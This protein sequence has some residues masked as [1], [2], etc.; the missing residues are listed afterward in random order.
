M[1]ISDFSVK[2]IEKELESKLKEYENTLMQF[3]PIQKNEINRRIRQLENRFSSLTKFFKFQ[4][5]SAADDFLFKYEKLPPFGKEYWF[6]YFV[7][8]KTKHQLIVTFGR[9]SSHININKL[10]LTG[11]SEETNISECAAVAWMFDKKRKILL[12][13]KQKVEVVYGEKDSKK[14]IEFEGKGNKFNFSGKYP[15][16]NLSLNTKMGNTHLELY[17]SKKGKPFEIQHLFAGNL[18]F[19]LVNLYFDFKGTLLG[20]KIEGKCYV[21]KVIV[22]SPFIPWNW[23]RFYFQDGS[24][25]EFFTPYIP[26]LP[27]KVKFASL[28]HYYDA[29]KNKTYKLKGLKIEKAAGLSRWHIFGDDYSLYARPYSEFLFKFEGLG[30]FKY[31]EY[32]TE[33]VDFYVMGKQLENGVGIIEDAYG[34]LV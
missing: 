19:G 28:V 30:F 12:N 17:R 15:N 29:K 8:P 20:K 1:R 10:E 16:Y 13:S 7:E 11:S 5:Y 21:Q 4:K 14:K 2:N 24:I 32:F 27:T 33:A 9:Y 23:G 31:Y 25:F 18:G 26:F 6:L 34:F 3:S 22:T